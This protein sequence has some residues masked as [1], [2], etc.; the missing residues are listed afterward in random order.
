MFT[1]LLGLTDPLVQAQHGPDRRDRRA[2]LRHRRASRWTSI[3]LA[4]HQRLAAAF[5]DGKMN[6]E[7]VHLYDTRGNV[8][9]EDTA[10]GAT[11]A[12]SSSPSSR[13]VFDRKYGNVTSGN[14]SQVTDGA[15]ML[16][17]ASEEAVQQIQAAGARRAARRR[18]GRGRTGA[19]GARAGARG[20][21]AA[22]GASISKMDDIKHM[23]LNEAFAAQVLGCQAAWASAE[24][25]K[26]ELGLDAPIGSMDPARLN[27][28][29]G[30]V[31]I[32]H[33]V[34]ASGARITLHLLQAR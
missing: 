21:R 8:A 7:I 23:E 2:S 28:H 5:D 12:S 27:P 14:S 29:G 18:L 31:A 22:S 11:P 20:G 25:C 3:A 17:L 24:Y 13:P 9:F 19:D 10:C 4:S 32:G 34:G 16:V 30:A 1:L 15:A 33:P 26:D 6:D